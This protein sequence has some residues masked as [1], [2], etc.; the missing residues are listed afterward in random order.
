MEGHDH[1]NCPF[2]LRSCPEHRFEQEQRL[3][4]AM[5]SDEDVSFI[6]KYDE[7]EPVLPHCNC[8]CNAIESGKVVGRCLHCDHIYADYSSVMEAQHFARNCPGVPNN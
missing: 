5:Y 6:R 2:E 3:A 7:R 8:G 4:G 1:S